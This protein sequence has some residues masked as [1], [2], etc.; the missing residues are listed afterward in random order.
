MALPSF[1]GAAFAGVIVDV[2][3]RQQGQRSRWHDGCA[4]HPRR[5]RCWGRPW[6]CRWWR[7]EQRDLLGGLCRFLRFGGRGRRRFGRHGRLDA[8]LGF[9]GTCWNHSHR[10][11]WRRWLHHHH[12]LGGA[13]PLKHHGH[14]GP[15]DDHGHAQHGH[16]QLG[17]SGDDLG[18]TLFRS[19][20]IICRGRQVAVQGFN[21]QL[22]RW[23]TFVAR[24]IPCFALLGHCSILA[25][26]K[27]SSSKTLRLLSSGGTATTRPTWQAPRIFQGPC[28]PR[29]TWRATAGDPPLRPNGGSCRRRE[30][31]ARPPRA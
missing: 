26:S 29:S 6:T 18:R 7:A 28:P 30:S 25:R 20:P 19:F 27:P 1:N 10:L 24:G 16:G 3:D 23:F 14:I 4:R 13:R 12:R 5:H 31:R 2:P 11:D 8:R 15:S 21:G 9:G 17:E 22:F